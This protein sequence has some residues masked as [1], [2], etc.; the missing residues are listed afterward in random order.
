MQEM[1]RKEREMDK[2]FAYDIMDK[3]QFGSLATVNEDC[4][5]YSVPISYVRKDNTIYIHS[6]LKGNKIDNI[7]RSPSISM[8]FVGDVNV[9]FPDEE[10]SVGMKP[11]EVFTTEFESAVVFGKAI[12]V[13]DSN[14]K[15]LGLRLLC[16][17]Y[18]PENMGFFTDAI[19]DAMHMTGVI[20]IDIE[21]ITGKRKKYDKDKVE[22]KWGREI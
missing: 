1:R 18:S 22:M 17:K 4:T 19:K 8:S 13:E 12:I 10:S 6:S 3:A 14:E 9:P 20:R 7:K 15:I 11:S 21:H 2:Q 16:E 5:P